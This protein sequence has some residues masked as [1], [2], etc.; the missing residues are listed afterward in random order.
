MER[1]LTG[2]VHQ[3]RKNNFIVMP[4]SKSLR[5]VNYSR[6]TTRVTAAP[7]LVTGLSFIAYASNIIFFSLAHFVVAAGVSA[8]VGVFSSIVG[9]TGTGNQRLNYCPI[10]TPLFIK[11]YE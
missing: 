8:V 7:M 10:T 3:T 2:T 4:V 1:E 5:N 11:T 6:K 9:N